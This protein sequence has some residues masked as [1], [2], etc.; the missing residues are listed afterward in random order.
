M[1]IY[2]I[3]RAGTHHPSSP[4]ASPSHSAGCT[5]AQRKMG[6]VK[7]SIDVDLVTHIWWLPHN[8][9]YVGLQQFNCFSSS[10]TGCSPFLLCDSNASSAECA[11][12]IQ[13]YQETTTSCYLQHVKINMPLTHPLWLSSQTPLLC[14]YVQKVYHLQAKRCLIFH[15]NER[16]A[17]MLW[18]CLNDRCKKRI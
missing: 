1:F 17:P 7:G 13:M 11:L 18:P 15:L 16:K 12:L 2:T 9:L 10:E 6:T 8:Q 14:Y 3:P 4:A 5:V